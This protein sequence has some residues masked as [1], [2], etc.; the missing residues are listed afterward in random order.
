LLSV[1]VVAEGVETRLPGALDVV[2]PIGDVPKRSG[3]EL[4]PT[5]AA[6]LAVRDES[7]IPQDT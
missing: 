3:H 4:M 6:D 7:G 5:L 2:N 1:E